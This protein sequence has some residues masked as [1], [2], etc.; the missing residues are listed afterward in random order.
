[1]KVYPVFM[2]RSDLVGVFDENHKPQAEQLAKDCDGY[3]DD[4]LALNQ[5][6]TADGKRFFDVI[7]FKDGQTEVT[8]KSPL[9]FPAS[10]R[11]E[12]YYLDNYSKD[13]KKHGRKTYWRLHVNCYAKDD[14]EAKSI[15]LVLRGQ[16]EKG[17]MPSD[18]HMW[19]DLATGAEKVKN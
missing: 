17:D 2:N 5:C 15:A 4:P 7:V 10:R 1:M 6:E 11:G 16:I 3:V 13:R 19:R 12:I 14:K 18:G 8:E 9:E